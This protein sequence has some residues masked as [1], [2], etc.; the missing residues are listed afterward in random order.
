MS[1]ALTESVD[2]LVF[3]RGQA[4]KDSLANGQLD[5]AISSQQLAKLWQRSDPVAAGISEDTVAGASCSTDISDVSFWCFT[6]GK[7]T[8][9]SRTEGKAW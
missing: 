2:G 6:E 8:G 9:S 3:T 1:V 4:F 5:T 7:R